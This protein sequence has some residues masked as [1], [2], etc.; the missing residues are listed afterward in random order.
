[1][2][3]S[4]QGTTLEE[5]DLL[6]RN[7]SVIDG[8]GGP[9]CKA[10]VAISGDEIVGVGQL[11][12]IHAQAE[13]DATGQC[14]APGFIDAHTHD[15]WALLRTPDMPFKVTQGVTT[16]IAGNC[17]ISAAPFRV[18]ED[19]PD[20]FNV[21][22]DVQS[23]SFKT[24]TEYRRAIKGE[25]P[26]VN[27]RL[28]AG[29]SSLRA[30]VMGPDLERAA[31]SAEINRMAE[32]LDKALSEGAAGLSSGLDYPA[33]MAAPGEEVVMLAR[34]LRH[35]PNTVYTT[36]VRD[37]GDGVIE[38]I[39]EALSTGQRADVPLILSHHKCAGSRNFG[40]SKTTLAMIDAARAK[41]EVAMD[42]YP[43]T[44]SS[45]ALM[46]RFIDAA[47]DVI[48]IWSAPHPEVGGRMLDDIAAEWGVSREEACTKLKPAGAIYF[49]MDEEDVQR[50]LQHPASMIGSDGLPGTEK[51]HPR[52]WGTFPRVLGHYTRDLKLFSLAQAV[53]KMT[54]LTAAKFG[55]TNRG[56][57]AVGKK[58]DLVLFD[59]ETISDV[60]DFDASERPAKGIHYV[61]VNGQVT[62]SQ[63]HQTHTR[64]GR[65]LNNHKQ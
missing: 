11:N 5:C 2:L 54:G 60:A 29:H 20:P 45:S 24:V 51:P 21:T 28:L 30:T 15:D 65:F 36:H 42:V 31:T 16:V 25:A 32:L 35:H 62:L 38:A 19:L 26:A 27:V 55:L 57:I 44:A 37:E 4:F 14:L 53:H 3:G 23:I 7:A 48:V 33:A 10:D 13:I 39:K 1:M 9:V 34:V 22:P 43:Y 40:K 41:A 18:Q 56:E 8:T 59:A 12:G 6:I 49:D 17:G 63:G 46:E 50:I 52:L 64:A 47:K 61:F 58:A